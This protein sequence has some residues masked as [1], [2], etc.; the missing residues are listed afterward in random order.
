MTDAAI[1]QGLSGSEAQRR[2]RELGEPPETSSR[3]V[4]SIVAGNVF[5]LFNLIIGVFF[6]VM[7]ALGLFADALFGFIAVINS[8]IGIRQEFGKE[9]VS[10][11]SFEYRFSELLKLVTSVAQGPFVMPSSAFA[12]RAP[13]EE[14]QKFWEAGDFTTQTVRRA[15]KRLGIHGTILA[16]RVRKEK[17]DY[18]ILSRVIHEAK[19]DR[20]SLHTSK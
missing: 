20:E 8:Y 17:N 12:L 6:V 15:A 19:I 2:L 10:S 4:A 13:E 16:G 11:V 18:Q 14:W 5:T 7:L 1:E 3:S 9:D